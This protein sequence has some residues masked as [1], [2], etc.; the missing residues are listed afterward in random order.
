MG[1]TPGRGFAFVSADERP[2]FAAWMGETIKMN[3][4]RA[5]FCERTGIA[6]DNATKY[7][8]GRSIPSKI[9][10]QRMIDT[11]IF[12]EAY[13]SVEHLV[14]DAPWMASR[15]RKAAATK[16]AKAVDREHQLAAPNQEP[17]VVAPAPAPSLLDV[18]LAEPGL[19]TQQRVQLSALAALII[20]GVDVHVSVSI[21]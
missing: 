3:G 20:N 19:T 1:L 16:T 4:G 6:L 13:G 5:A 21:R 14:S 10:I 2:A 11:G 18:I 15:F 17:A 9:N 7:A 8:T 12:G